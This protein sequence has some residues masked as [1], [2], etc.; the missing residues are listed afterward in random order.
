MI[1]LVNAISTFWNCSLFHLCFHV[2]VR[3]N[4][5]FC[6]M[7]FASGNFYQIPVFVCQFLLNL[8]IEKQE[9]LS[10]TG[11]HF[12]SLLCSW[13]AVPMGLWLVNCWEM[14]LPLLLVKYSYIGSIETFFGEE[15]VD[16][17][18]RK[19]NYSSL[20]LLGLFCLSVCSESTVCKLLILPHSFFHCSSLL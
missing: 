8:D 6:N 13:H 16:Q 10:I 7:E 17:R 5:L 12:L 11:P 4:F 14:N 20:Q 19:C 9:F 18:G 2:V 15:E 3:K 1:Q